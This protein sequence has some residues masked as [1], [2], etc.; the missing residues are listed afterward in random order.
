MNWL[1]IAERAEKAEGPDRALDDA[2]WWLLRIEG[3]FYREHAGRREHDV[4]C[5]LYGT[6]VADWRPLGPYNEAPRYTASV[7]A[8]LAL[9]TEQLPG[10]SY[11]AEGGPDG[12]AWRLNEDNGF[13]SRSAEGKHPKS[14]CLA[15]LAAFARAMSAQREEGE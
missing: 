12:H 6:A 8:V 10:W 4:T 1:E 5:G 11:E 2:A 9:T 7:D 15:R 13:G 14:E 3:G